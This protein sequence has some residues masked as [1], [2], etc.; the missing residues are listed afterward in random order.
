MVE[1]ETSTADLDMTQQ[2]NHFGECLM[3]VY[4]GRTLHIQVGTYDRKNKCYYVD[5]ANG[6]ELKF[7]KSAVLCVE[8][9]V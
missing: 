6:K 9:I 1:Y 3:T 2:F 5:T 4:T 8:V 7:R